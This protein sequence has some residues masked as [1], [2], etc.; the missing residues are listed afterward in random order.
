MA[1]LG[2]CIQCGREVK[3]SDCGYT[4]FHCGYVEG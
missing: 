2:E 1:R 4:C 3:I